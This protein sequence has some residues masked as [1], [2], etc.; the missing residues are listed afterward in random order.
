MLAR[1]LLYPMCMK[2]HR[3]L[4][5]AVMALSLVVA[6][7]AA[8][9][10]VIG[11]RNVTQFFAKERMTELAQRLFGREAE[12]HTVTGSEPVVACDDVDDLH[13]IHARIE[14]L[15]AE[16]ASG[17]MPSSF[18]TTP[19]PVPDNTAMEHFYRLQRE[20]DRIFTHAFNDGLWRHT[21]RPVDW[22]WEQAAVSPALR[23]TEDAQAYEITVALT[24]VDRL[25]IDVQLHGDILS[26]MA[27]GASNNYFTRLRLPEAVDRENIQAQYEGNVLRV[28]VPKVPR[29]T[30]QETLATPRQII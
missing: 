27:S 16:L 13:E 29:E 12:P 21:R 2:T 23:M 8:L 4:R 28:R 20:I 6:V 17:A 9:L 19:A 18:A 7:E 3:K 5:W 24:D 26:I 22:R 30:P 25:G 15:F 14:R 11:W 10:T 1:L